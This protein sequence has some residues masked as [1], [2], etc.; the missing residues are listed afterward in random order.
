MSTLSG[1]LSSTVAAAVAKGAEEMIGQ[2][3]PRLSAQV[4][5]L[6]LKEFGNMMFGDGRFFEELTEN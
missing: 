6:A 4:M 2:L 5:P 3:V 1:S